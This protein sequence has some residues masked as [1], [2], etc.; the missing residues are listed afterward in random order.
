LFRFDLIRLEVEL[1]G[2]VTQLPLG[3]SVS[4]AFGNIA[5]LVGAVAECVRV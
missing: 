3:L 2:K 1:F 4:S 5:T